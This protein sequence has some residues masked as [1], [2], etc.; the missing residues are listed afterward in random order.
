MGFSALAVGP[1]VTG[2]VAG[3]SCSSDWAQA[4]STSK[5]AATM[6][7]TVVNFKAW[8]PRL[9]ERRS[10][11]QSVTAVSVGQAGPP[12]WP[13]SLSTR[14][15]LMVGYPWFLRLWPGVSVLTHL[16]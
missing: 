9:P 12:A 5:S 8:R 11:I 6:E 13:Q 2:A 1:A 3:G 4:A 10:F 14:P 15:K 7:D 16:G